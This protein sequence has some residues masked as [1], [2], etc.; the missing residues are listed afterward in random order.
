MGSQ[1]KS[2]HFFDRPRRLLTGSILAAPRGAPQYLP[3]CRAIT[4]AAKARRIDKGFQIVNGM[5]IDTQPILRHT[6]THVT[7]NVGGQMRHLNPR[8]NQ[9]ARVISQQVEVSFSGFGTPSNEA[10]AAA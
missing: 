3:V 5:R 2:E 4:G 10:V 9:K 6:L 1:W 7:Q 8:Q